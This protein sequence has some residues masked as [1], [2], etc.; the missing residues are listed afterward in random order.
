LTT[1]VRHRR[2]RRCWAT[3]TGC[4]RCVPVTVVDRFLHSMPRWLAWCVVQAQTNRFYCM[5]CSEW[6]HRNRWCCTLHLQS[7]VS[8]WS[9][10]TA[11]TLESGSVN[12]AIQH[13][14]QWYPRC[15][16]HDVNVDSLLRMASPCSTRK[17]STS[18][19]PHTAR[20]R[21]SWSCCQSTSLSLPSRHHPNLPPLLNVVLSSALLWLLNTV[22]TCLSNFGKKIS[23]FLVL[24]HM[25]PD[26]DM[27]AGRFL[28]GQ[29]ITNVCVSLINYCNLIMSSLLMW[30]NFV[31]TLMK[32]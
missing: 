18:W 20:R 14:H 6:S 16:V 3:S 30:Y 13:T 17:L 19:E 27:M 4:S 22:W 15:I 28:H 26:C 29:L 24:R 8:L 11:S 1:S 10:D 25:I 2:Q 12:V 21:N 9:I 32:T 5:C 7:L 23:H 31:Q